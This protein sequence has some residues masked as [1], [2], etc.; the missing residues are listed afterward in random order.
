MNFKLLLPVIAFGFDLTSCA[1]LHK[2]QLGDVE[3]AN[4]AKHVSVK[5]SE[6]TLDIREMG[7]L[8]KFGGHAFKS[9]GASTLGKRLEA[10][11]TLF[12]FGPRTGTPVYNEEYAR[13][14]P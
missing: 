10:Y 9:K 3:P 6:T 1:A 5:V 4:R 11:T 2:T 8:A 13:F 12:Q 14:I 7:E